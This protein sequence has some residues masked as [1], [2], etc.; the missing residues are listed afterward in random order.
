MPVIKAEVNDVKEVYTVSYERNGKLKAHNV[1][2]IN[3]EEAK[4][5]F[6]RQVRNANN[7][8]EKEIKKVS[9]LTATLN[10]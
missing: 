2:V 5:E 8:D 3:E 7:G 9:V 10:K 6:M 4:K 1:M